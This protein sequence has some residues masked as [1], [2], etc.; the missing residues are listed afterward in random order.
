[1]ADKNNNKSQ[2]LIIDDDPFI[3]QVLKKQF[4]KL[5]FQTLYALTIAQGIDLIFT[6]KFDVVFLDVILPDGNGLKAINKIK[7]HPCAP[8]IIIITGA[9]D[10]EW[11][12]LA[13]KL[14]AWDY[15]QKSSSQKNIHFSL[16]RA[17]E[18]RKQKI[19]KKKPLKR[20]SIVG[21]S[22][23]ITACLEK[24]TNASNNDSPVLIRGETGTGK[25]LFAKAIHKNSTRNKNDFI[26]VDC[27]ALPEHLVESVL[28]GHLKGSFTSAATN[29]AGLLKL[30]DKGTLFLDEIG[31]L[32]VTIQKKFLRALQEKKFRPIGSE[33]EI[34]SNFKLIAATHRDLS[35]MIKD[36]DFREDLFFRIASLRINIAPLRDRKSDIPLLVKHHMDRKN[37]LFDGPAQE[38]SDEFMNDLIQYSWPGNVR[39][40]FNT[41]DYAGSEAFM[42]SILFPKH[43]PDYIRT[44]NLQKKL[45]NGKETG[46]KE[47]IIKLSLKNYLGKMKKQY[48]IDLMQYTN[49]DIKAACLLSDLSRGHLYSL[50]KEF[51]IKSS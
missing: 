38:I 34:T 9:F 37:K 23:Q 47:N 20:D 35:N 25:E 6:H 36:K 2:I 30:A 29:R 39:E 12:E 7:E 17:L 1:M 32:P 14:K 46:E 43:L 16:I 10:P 26:V 50:L 42:E 21:N 48:L 8:E 33:K 18:Y 27:A 13:M 15:I 51:N 3:C 11:A 44:F 28:F 45:K 40:L 5:G 4:E 19:F 31:E 49:G 41:L 24:V 22:R